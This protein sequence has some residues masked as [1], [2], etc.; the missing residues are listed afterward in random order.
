MKLACVVSLP[1]VSWASHG[2]QPSC[3]LNMQ[4][5]SPDLASN[6][7]ASTHVV[8]LHLISSQQLC[9]VNSANDMRGRFSSAGASLRRASPS[10]YWQSDWLSCSSLSRDWLFVLLVELEHL[11]SLAAFR[12]SSG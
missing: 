10:G 8:L 12:A 4:A 1:Y 11:E 6:R 9:K 2:V 5:H 3:N 7:K